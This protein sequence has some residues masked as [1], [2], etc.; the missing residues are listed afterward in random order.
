[1]LAVYQKLLKSGAKIAIGTDA[2]HGELVEDILMVI[3]TMDESVARTLQGVT[4]KA[5]TV[6]GLDHLV[7][8]VTAG[9]KAD[10]IAVGGNVE[11]NTAAL[12][13]VCFVMKD[14]AVITDSRQ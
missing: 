11:Q 9:K 7:G 14:G 8:S 12:R 5:A 13:A 1:M 10:L 6:S 4:S 3:N 2:A